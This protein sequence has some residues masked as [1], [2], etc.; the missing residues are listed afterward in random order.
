[1]SAGILLAI[2]IN[3][4]KFKIYQPVKQE[5]RHITATSI[6][7]HTGENRCVSSVG[8]MIFKGCDAAK[9]GRLEIFIFEGNG[10]F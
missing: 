8:V 4:L 10:L 7:V 2:I 6:E 9:N 1:M 5:V 3:K